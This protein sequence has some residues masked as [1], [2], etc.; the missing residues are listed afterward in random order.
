MASGRRRHWADGALNAALRLQ[1]RETHAARPSAAAAAARAFYS[2]GAARAWV[3]PPSQ[4]TLPTPPQ[5]D[6][7]RG[8]WGSGVAARAP[9]AALWRRNTA[10]RPAPHS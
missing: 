8:P 9:R 3:L 2:E 6:Q 7:T 1:G 5:C 4:A 10:P